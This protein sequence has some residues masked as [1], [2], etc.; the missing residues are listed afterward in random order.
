MR[1]VSYTIFLVVQGDVDAVVV[2][3]DEKLQEGASEK[4]SSVPGRDRVGNLQETIAQ[5]SR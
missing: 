1:V 2:C 5:S 4:V 3:L